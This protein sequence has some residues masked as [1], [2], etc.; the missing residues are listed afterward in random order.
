[1]FRFNHP[2][3]PRERRESKSPVAASAPAASVTETPVSLENVDWNFAQIEL[4]EKQGIDLKVAF[5]D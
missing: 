2:G 1:V 4:L 3:Q 5:L